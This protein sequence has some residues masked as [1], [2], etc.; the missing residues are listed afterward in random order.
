MA[1]IWYLVW[2]LEA[3]MCRIVRQASGSL[4]LAC[5]LFSSLHST[6]H[7]S[8]QALY[9]H[10]G[11]HFVFVLPF[12]FSGQKP[13]P[14]PRPSITKATWESNYFGVPL[15]TVVT[16]EKPIP[17]FIE[18]CIEYIEATGKSYLTADCPFYWLKETW[19]KFL[20]AVI[21]QCEML[22]EKEAGDLTAVRL[23]VPPFLHLW[24]CRV[25]LTR[26]QVCWTRS[27]LRT[28]GVAG[29]SLLFCS[30]G[31]WTQGL[32]LEPLY[33]SFF[34]GEVFEIGSRE[35]FA[36]TGFESRSSWSLPPE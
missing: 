22:S 19:G 26:H 23:M 16:P 35:L 10:A 34:C 31:V 8:L 30:T 7:S 32:H 14:K 18:R 15:T 5:N 17:I 4:Y 3:G 29:L 1:T 28:T 24:S 2:Y 11:T 12:L 9:I 27:V 13:K 25:A 36:Q 6:A 20:E 21:V 33:Q